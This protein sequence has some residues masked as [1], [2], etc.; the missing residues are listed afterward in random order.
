MLQLIKKTGVHW[1]QDGVHWRA[2][3]N[4]IMNI[5]FLKSGQFLDQLSDCHFLPVL[6]LAQ[7]SGNR[8]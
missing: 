8:D 3:L 2:V 5:M 4:T 6:G 1:V 7:V